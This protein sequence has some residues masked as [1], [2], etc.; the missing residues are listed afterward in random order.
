MMAGKVGMVRHQAY[1]CGSPA[2]VAAAR[3]DFL[4]RCHL[5]AEEFFADSFDFASDTLAAIDTLHPSDRKV[6]PL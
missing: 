3:E 6:D 2:M 5:P 1:V 4:T